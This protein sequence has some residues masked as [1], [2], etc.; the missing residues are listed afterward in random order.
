MRIYGGHDYYDCGLSYGI[1]PLIT[2]V[3]HKNETTYDM[4][5]TF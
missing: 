5:V 4:K 2:L 3:R 1:D